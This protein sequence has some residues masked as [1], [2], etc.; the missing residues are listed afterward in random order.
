VISNRRFT[1]GFY[2]IAC[3]RPKLTNDPRNTP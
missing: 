1:A 2:R 3:T